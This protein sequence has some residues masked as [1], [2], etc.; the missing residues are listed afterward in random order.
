MSTKEPNIELDIDNN[1]NGILIITCPEC[2]RKMKK[3]LRELSPNK[4]ISCSC[5]FTVNFTGDD[6]R[7]TQRSLNDLKRTLNNFG[8]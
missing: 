5:G 8:K 6:L 1:L 3:K 4:E 2:R 7:S